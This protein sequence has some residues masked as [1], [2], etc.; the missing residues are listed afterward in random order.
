MSGYGTSC[1][2]RLSRNFVYSSRSFTTFAESVSESK[3]LMKQVGTQRIHG[4]IGDVVKHF[5]AAAANDTDAPS[6][7]DN[8]DRNSFAE[9]EDSEAGRRSSRRLS[10]EQSCTSDELE[11]DI[12]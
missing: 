7:E 5:G 2:S 8:R 12:E 11:S 6:E 4:F 3:L 10:P 1:H 9:T